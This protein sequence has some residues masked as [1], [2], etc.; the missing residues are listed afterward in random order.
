[1]IAA[2]LERSSVRPNTS[3]PFNCVQIPELFIAGVLVGTS[4]KLL[5]EGV[6]LPVR[7]ASVMTGRPPGLSA[8]VLLQLTSSGTEGT[9]LT[10][11]VLAEQGHGVL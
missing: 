7:P 5:F 11:I 2:G 6:V 3:E 1:M 9:R 8:K 10:V 4:D